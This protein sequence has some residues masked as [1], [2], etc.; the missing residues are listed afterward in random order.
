MKRGGEKRGMHQRFGKD[1]GALLHDG[2]IARRLCQYCG[3][4]RIMGMDGGKIKAKATFKVRPKT[5][6]RM[7][8]DLWKKFSKCEEEGGWFPRCGIIRKDEGRGGVLGQGT[9]YERH[10]RNHALQ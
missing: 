7:G 9:V 10:R 1:L 4:K 5:K 6:D 2:D 3:K 8:V